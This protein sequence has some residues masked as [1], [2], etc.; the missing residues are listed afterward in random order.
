MSDA[1]TDAPI[2]G[3][4]FVA[5]QA[6]I[7][8]AKSYWHTD[9]FPALTEEYKQAEKASAKPLET[10]DDVAEVMEHNTLYQ[11]FAWCERYL[12][13]YKYSGR[14][15]LVPYY[16]QMRADTV[17]LFKDIPEDQLELNDDLDMPRYYESFDIHQHP[18]GVWSDVVSGL[19]YER[20]ASTTTPL[21]GNRHADLHERFAD[22]L[23]QYSPA[24]KK[25]LE[26]ACG[27]GK[28]T[29][30]LY[31]KYQDAEIEAIDLSG[32][33]IQV[34][35]LR[36]KE[37]GARNVRFRQ[38]DAAATDYDDASFD[39]VTSSMLLHEMPPPYIEK[40]FEEAARVTKPGG[41][42][43]HL[44]F[45][46]LPD[47]FRRFIHYTH[48]RR[49]NEPFMEPLAELDLPKLLEEKGFKDIKIEAF[50]ETEG[51]LDPSFKSWR[52]PW[53]I[54]RATRA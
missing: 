29:R 37:S 54:I 44:D 30:A 23:E 13:R 10:V 35:A 53:T 41:E 20:A 14:Y 46:Y 17:E 11:Y 7:T 50:A 52:Y 49:N 22:L 48:G 33:C 21:A 4:S 38:M 51:V 40:T 24:P 28:T 1:Y 15:G 3:R 47:L 36:A 6:F 27:F 34:G 39:L 19:V 32:P 12:Q 8:G 31:N 18:G 2:D 42:M 43:V 16:R 25:V 5:G 45:W 26:M 9:L